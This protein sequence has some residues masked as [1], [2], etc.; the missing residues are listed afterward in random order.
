MDF[1]TYVNAYYLFIIYKPLIPAVDIRE[2]PIGILQQYMY[3]M[4][5]SSVYSVVLTLITS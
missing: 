2:C 4:Y 5:V 3:D 1:N